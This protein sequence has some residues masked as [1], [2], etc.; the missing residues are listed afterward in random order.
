MGNKRWGPRLRLDGLAMIAAY[1]KIS[2]NQVKKLYASTVSEADRLPVFTISPSQGKN[3]RL[4]IYVDEL[5]SWMD[6]QPDMFM[7]H[8]RR[9]I[10]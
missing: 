2:E 8:H 3:C 9:K 6:R 5:D 1:M 7:H 4:S 10:G